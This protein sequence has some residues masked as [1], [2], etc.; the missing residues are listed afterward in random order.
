MLE[1]NRLDPPR[2]FCDP[3]ASASGSRPPLDGGLLFV[4]P[5]DF[6]ATG[7]LAGFDPCASIYWWMPELHTQRTAA[8]PVR[9]G[10][11]VGGMPPGAGHQAAART[12][13]PTT[14]AA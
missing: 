7:I 11:R 8:A 12:D 3:I 2:P 1:P 6:D 10:G 4:S 13:E 9:T 14:A 5:E